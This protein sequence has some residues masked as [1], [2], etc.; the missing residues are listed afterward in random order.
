[1]PIEH[2]SRDLAAAGQLYG[3]TAPAAPAAPRRRALGAPSGSAPA[4]G[5]RRR[6]RAPRVSCWPRQ[7]EQPP[8][9]LAQH[10]VAGGVA[11]G[12]VD[13]L[14]AVEVDEQHRHRAGCAADALQRLVQAL[15]EQQ[16]VGQRRQRIAKGLAAQLDV[17]LVQRSRQRAVLR[18][19]APIEPGTE[20]SDRHR[21]RADRGRHR[22]AERVEAAVRQRPAISGRNSMPRSA[23]ACAPASPMPST[24]MPTA[25][26]GPRSSR[27]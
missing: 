1:M 14:E 15:F 12:V 19:V 11:E 6:R 5:T 23:S 27:A 22:E 2:D 26:C 8:A 17:G 10:H 4:A 24:V 3:A 13:R 9:D 16:P 18:A 20:H 25:A 7:L 21:Q